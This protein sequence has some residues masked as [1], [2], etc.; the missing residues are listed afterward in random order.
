MTPVRCGEHFEGGTILHWFAG[1]EGRGVLLAGDIL[2][3]CQDRRP[4][5]FMYSYPN[6]VPL[7]A[8]A[9]R[10]AVAAV[11][12]FAFDQI[13]GF[14]FDLV[15]MEDTKAAVSRSAYRYM[16]AIGAGQAPR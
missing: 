13:Y 15:I 9:V 14:M 3:I 7:D 6:Y 11:G 16:R 2:Q 1:A 8:G 10:R 5:N 4:V 12:P